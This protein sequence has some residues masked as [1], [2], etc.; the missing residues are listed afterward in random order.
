LACKQAAYR[1]TGKSPPAI[2]LH[3]EL[4][5]RKQTGLPWLSQVS[6]CA[7]PGGLAQPGRRRRPLL[8]PLP[9]QARRAATGEGG[10]S[11][12]ET[13]K[14]GL[15][16]FRLTGSIVV[17][18]DAIQLPRLGR[19]RLLRSGAICRWPAPEGVW[20]RS[21]TVSEQAGRWEVS[22]RVEQAQE[23]EVRVHPGPVV[24]VELGIKTLDTFS[25]GALL[26]NSRPLQ[27]RLKTLQR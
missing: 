2:D 22:L 7:P 9:A 11:T 24:G 27:C 12:L 17:F 21:A 18:P 16:S 26:A 6:T 13:K 4:N 14:C 15:G 8:P 19:L 25:D 10:V 20:V 3:R 5:T 1:A 23:Q